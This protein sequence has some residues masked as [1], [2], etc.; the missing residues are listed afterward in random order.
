MVFS[1]SLSNGTKLNTDFAQFLKFF[2]M[3]EINVSVKFKPAHRKLLKWGKRSKYCLMKL[4]Y[5][6]Q[7]YQ[8]LKGETVFARIYFCDSYGYNWIYFVFRNLQ[9]ANL[10][11][12]N[13]LV[14]RDSLRNERAKA[15]TLEADLAEKREQLKAQISKLNTLNNQAEEEMVQLR[16]RCVFTVQQFDI[17]TQRRDTKKRDLCEQNWFA[18]SVIRYEIAVQHRNDRGVQLVEREEEV[19]I[20]Y[21]KSNIQDIMISNGDVAVRALEEE[22]R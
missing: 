6:E 10:K 13:S 14:L 22:I 8:I 16:K 20:F 3:R 17:L 19:C 7:L 4:K 15:L 21:E 11:Q 12:M 2:R 18:L 9:K 1:V 5:W